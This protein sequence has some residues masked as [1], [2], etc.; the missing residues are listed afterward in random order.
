[1]KGKFYRIAEDLAH[2]ISE[3]ER[4]QKELDDKY[5]EELDGDFPVFPVRQ[6]QPKGRVSISGDEIWDIAT[7][8][9]GPRINC[10]PGK[11]GA[12]CY[13][14]AL[15]FSIQG[16]YAKIYAKKGNYNIGT[17]LDKFVNHFNDW[18]IGR[19]KEAAIFTNAWWPQDYDKYFND[20]QKI[21]MRNVYIEAYFIGQNVRNIPPGQNILR[22]NI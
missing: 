9:F 20:I 13:Q 21:K 17:V 18:C 5:S 14:T 11:K 3:K 16:F 1:M 10:Y 8:S 15:F 22:L 2:A 4:L 7:K 12:N 19:T 6:E